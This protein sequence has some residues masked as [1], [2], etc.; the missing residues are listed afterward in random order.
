MSEIASKRKSE[1]A[2]GREDEKGP[3]EPMVAAREDAT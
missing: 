3:W 2:G 1:K